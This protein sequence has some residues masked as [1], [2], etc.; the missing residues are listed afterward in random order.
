MAESYCGNSCATCKK[1]EELHCPGCKLGP[2]KHYSNDC[3]IAKC[4]RENGHVSCQTCP[5]SRNYCVKFNA[6]LNAAEQRIKKQRDDMWARDYDRKRSEALGKWLRIL[7]WLRIVSEIVGLF[8]SEL[9]GSV[10]PILGVVTSFVD[11]ALS[12]AM[13]LVLVEL[14]NQN[15]G[16][17]TGGICLVVSSV[18]GVAEGLFATMLEGTVMGFL[19]SIPTIVIG[20]L[21]HYKIYTAHSE[22]LAGVDDELSE[23]W[24]G[25]W[26]W[27][28]GLIAV[29]LGSRLVT[30][31]IPLFGILL[32]LIGTF[33][34]LVVAVVEIVYLYKTSK[35]FLNYYGSLQ[36]LD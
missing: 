4:C 26:K 23:K 2:G 17:R 22:E 16:Y 33:G 9:L 21:G 29:S 32:A 27:Y 19:F 18:M 10:I 1:K 35:T 20:V 15:S 12:I 11:L 34:A 28:I 14:G 13:V 24:V 31:L 6:R 8:G 5:H 3:E 7:F 25:L 36:H 30:L